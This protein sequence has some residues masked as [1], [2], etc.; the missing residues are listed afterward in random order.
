MGDLAATDSYPPAGSAELAP[1]TKAGRTAT[2]APS[3]KD[4]LIK[5]LAC[6]ATLIIAGWSDASSGPLIPYIQRH[7]GIGYTTVSLLF[8]GQMVGFLVGAFSNGHLTARYGIGKVI[9]IGSIVQALGYVFLV[10]AWAFPTF[11]IFYAVVG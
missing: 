1:Q 9:T 5:E 2:V 3:K 11:P 7:F 4:M 10:P 6:H 8:V